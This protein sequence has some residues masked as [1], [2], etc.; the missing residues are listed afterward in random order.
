M[1]AELV[2]DWVCVARCEI[3]GRAMVGYGDG[4]SGGTEEGRMSL[5]KDGCAMEVYKA[6]MLWVG[7][8]RHALTHSITTTLSSLQTLLHFNIRLSR[9]S[10]FFPLHYNRIYI[11]HLYLH[12]LLR[13]PIFSVNHNHNDAIHRHPR[14][15]RG[16]WRR[17]VRQLD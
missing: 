14:H 8:D 9:K 11:F 2:R 15:P 4:R 3:Q 6:G 16:L 10:P 7:R 1:R 17:R 13:Y 12:L 5:A